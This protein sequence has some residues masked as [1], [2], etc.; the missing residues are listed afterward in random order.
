MKSNPLI[1]ASTSMYR[2]QLLSRLALDFINAAPEI[3][4]LEKEGETPENLAK[5]LAEEKATAL[6]EK[7]PEHLII[8]SDQVASCEGEILGKPGDFLTACQQLLRQSGRTVDFYTGVAVLNSKT[9]RCLT[10]CDITQVQFRVLSDIE[11]QTYL[12]IERPFDCAG[13]FKAEGLGICLFEKI[14]SED[15]TGLIGL[16]LIKTTSLLKAQ[17]L[18]IPPEKETHGKN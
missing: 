12:N 10:A 16:P 18:K 5:R 17:G 6:V 8:G 15:P 3:E 11:I 4:E 14:H 1:L 2:Q 9:G 7:F 13:S